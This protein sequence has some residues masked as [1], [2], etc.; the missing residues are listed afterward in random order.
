MI[1]ND[2]AIR[3]AQLDDIMQLIPQIPDVIE[4]SNERTCPAHLRWLLDRCLDE[5]LTFPVDKMGRTIGYVYGVL[6]MSGH[7][8]VDTS[9]NQTRKTYHD[10]Y[11]ATGQAIPETVERPC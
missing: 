11:R 8:D 10:A 1:L 9:R 6:A 4:G 3:S 2:D 7:L 5:A